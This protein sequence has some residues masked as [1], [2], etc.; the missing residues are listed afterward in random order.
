VLDFSNN[1]AKLGALAGLS[2]T[3]V[4]SELAPFVSKIGQGA[5][6]TFFLQQ[7]FPFSEQNLNLKDTLPD[8]A[9]NIVNKLAR[10]NNEKNYFYDGGV[11][12]VS[13]YSELNRFARNLCEGYFGV[14]LMF[15]D[16]DNKSSN[17]RK[18]LGT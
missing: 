16:E 4:W 13:D 6:L 11:V 3:A 17:T 2:T 8:Y 5:E 18:C 12:L 15:R 1:L 10:K 9:Q 7:N 14:G